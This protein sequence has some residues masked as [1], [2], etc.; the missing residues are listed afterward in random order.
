[1]LYYTQELNTNQT[2]I[3]QVLTL[4]KSKLHLMLKCFF[5]LSCST[6]LT[7]LNRHLQKSC[8][9]FHSD[10]LIIVDRSLMKVK[11]SGLVLRT[12]RHLT[13]F[14]VHSACNFWKQVILSNVISFYHIT[15]FRYSYPKI[16]SFLRNPTLIYKGKGCHIAI[17][18]AQL[19]K[20]LTK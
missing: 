3:T 13:E 14:V 10:T 2:K 1:M 8:R 11:Y 19:S 6:L 16:L 18:A 15:L 20:F 4:A 17:K 12:S 9:I 7:E 5:Q